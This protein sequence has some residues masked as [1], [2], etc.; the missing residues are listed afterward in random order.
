MSGNARYEWWPTYQAENFDVAHRGAVPTQILGV[1][2]LGGTLCIPAVT[3]ATGIE[4]PII[5]GFLGAHLLW[6][7]FGVYVL[8]A[9]VPGPS[10]VNVLLAGNLVVNI[11]VAVGIPLATRDPAT[12]LWMLPVVYA[13]LNGSLQER[14]LCLTFLLAHALSPL[15]ALVVLLDGRERTHWSIAAPILCA[16]LCTVAYNHLANMAAQWRRSRTEQEEALSE[17]RA[18]IAMRDRERLM[19]DLR[20]SLGATLSVVATY[21]EL[22]ERHLDHPR[23][24]RAVATMVREAARA[25]LGDLRGL[26]GAIAPAAADLEGVA[27]TLRQAAARMSDGTNIE[28]FVRTDGSNVPIHGAA[29]LAIVRAFQHVARDACDRPSTRRIVV[30]LGS[31]HATL[32]LSIEDDGACTRGDLVRTGPIDERITELGGTLT[33]TPGT[34]QGMLVR[35]SLPTPPPSD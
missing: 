34:N 30:Q 19:G 18:R 8:A 4:A 21:G 14:K 27:D 33:R 7:L 25:G 15:V 32:V 24:L 5:V 28:I 31:Q 26:L 2:I 1:A 11:G 9:R 6:L 3:H 23:E 12:P 35:V 16:V 22:V 10:R 17:L 29:R 20:D 13:C